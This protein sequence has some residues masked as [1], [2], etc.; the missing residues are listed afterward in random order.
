MPPLLSIVIP[1]HNH[2]EALPELLES[3]SRQSF[4]DLEVVVVDDASTES[5]EYILEQHRE[6]G[7]DIKLHYSPKRLYTKDAR[8]RGIE[9][10]KGEII[11]FADA[12]DAFTGRD[13]LEHHVRRYVD[14][15]CDVLHFCTM[16]RHQNGE[17][18]SFNAWADPFAEELKGEDIFRQYAKTLAGHLMWNKLY[19]RRLWMRHIAAAKAVPI[20]VCSEDLFLSTFYLFHAR[21]YLGSD[22]VGY[23][24]EYLD[25]TGVKSACRSVAFFIM[26]RDFFPYLEAKACPEDILTMLA[27][28]FESDCQSY[29]NRACLEASPTPAAPLERTGMEAAFK[30]MPKDVLLD[31]LIYVNGQN[32]NFLSDCGRSF[33]RAPRD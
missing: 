32:A 17:G 9:V 6:K 28:R 15:G 19:S 21:H 13:I 26:L 16:R 11:A 33:Y 1:I 18:Q 2:A 7:L 5:C 20:T 14:S 25:K 29:V 22:K 3:I 30:G 23:A 8:L 27:T 12:D 4:T 31:M 24:H 10:A